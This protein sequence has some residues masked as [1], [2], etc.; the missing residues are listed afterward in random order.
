LRKVPGV[1]VDLVNGEH[2]ELTVSVDGHEVARKEGD[3]FPQADKVVAAVQQA[4]M[5]G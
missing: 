4:A 1:D 2:G 3:T 5:A